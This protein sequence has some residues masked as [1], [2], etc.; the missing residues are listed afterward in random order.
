MKKVIKRF[1]KDDSGAAMV[2]YALL[3]AV[4]ALVAVG[5]A[6]TVGTDLKKSFEN[7]RNQLCEKNAAGT[8]NAG[9]CK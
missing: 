3:V 6:V 4:I 8:T 5:G 1:G 9:K 2:E 7:M